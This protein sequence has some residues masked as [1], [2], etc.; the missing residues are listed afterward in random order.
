L[1][2]EYTVGMEFPD[3]ETAR[4]LDRGIV[5]N[6]SD[7]VEGLVPLNQ[8]GEEVNHPS[9]IY[10][11]GDR[12]PATVIE[13]DME[14]RKIVLSI[15]EYFKGK[16]AK[17]WADHQAKYPIKPESEVKIPKKKEDE[18]GGEEAPGGAEDKA[19]EEEKAVAAATE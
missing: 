19:P 11:V 10:K 18:E 12:V 3:C 14:G 5:V 15:S 7:E 2:K 13:F 4:I 17:L 8:L 16:D 1:A 6:L 9:R